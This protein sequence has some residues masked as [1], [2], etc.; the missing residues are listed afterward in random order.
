MH[1]RVMNQFKMILLDENEDSL[2]DQD[3]NG[4][5]PLQLLTQTTPSL[6]RV[7]RRAQKNFAQNI[8]ISSFLTPSECTIVKSIKQ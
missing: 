4:R 3:S 8:I 1:E 2:V 6:I 7:C 5:T